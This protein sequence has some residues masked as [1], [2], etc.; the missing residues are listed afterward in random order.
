[1]KRYYHFSRKLACVGQPQSLPKAKYLP[2]SV[3]LLLLALCQFAAIGAFGQ[4]CPPAAGGPPY[5][6]GNVF[7]DYGQDGVKD[8]NV[9]I[10]QPIQGVLVRAFNDAGAMVASGSSQADG[11]YLLVNAGLV[12]G[13]TYRLEFSNFPAQ[14]FG[15]A[16]G[17]GNGTSVQFAAAN[18]CNNNFALSQPDIYCQSNPSFALNCYIEGPNTG[19]GDVLISIPYNA[20]PQSNEAND[21]NQ[22]KHEAIASAIGTTYGLAYQRH[23]KTLFA[24]AFMKRFAGF[25]PGGP[26]AIYKVPNPDD[27]VNSGSLFLNLSTVLGVANVAGADPHNFTTKTSGGDV[28]DANSYNAVTRV[29][30]GDMDISDDELS[31]WTINLA[32]R[33][34]YKIPLGTD[35]KNPVAPTSASQITVIPLASAASP[36][37]GLPTGLNNA[38]IRPF[39]L[40]FYKGKVYVSLVTNGQ[41]GGALR[42]YVYSYDPGPGTFTKELDF[43]LDYN[44][45]CGFGLNNSCY[46]PAKWQP[47]VN[48]NARPTPTVVGPSQYREDGYP[49]P[50]LT[51]IEFDI[52][53]NMILGMRDRFGDQE[54]RQAPRPDGNNALVTGDAFGDL[55]KATK[56]TTGWTINMA[57][58]TDPTTA[59]ATSEPVFGTDNYEDGGFYHEETAMGSLGVLLRANSLVTPVMD[60]RAAAFSNGVDW[61]NLTPANAPRFKSLTVLTG[62]AQNPFGKAYGLGDIEFVCALAPIEIGNRVW[63]D[64]NKNGIQDPNEPPLVGVTVALC[65]SAGAAIPNATAVTDAKGQYIFSSGEGTNNA[66]SKF[67]LAIKPLTTYQV[68]ITALG[69]NASVTGIALTDVTP[70]TPGEPGAVNSGATINNND[71]KLVAGKPTI[72]FITGAEGENNHTYDFALFCEKPVITAT[73]YTEAT[74]PTNGNTTPNNNASLKVTTDGTKA[75]ISVTG[76]PTTTFA[77]ATAVP[78]SGANA[79]MVTFGSLNGTGRLALRAGVQKPGLLHRHDCCGDARRVLPHGDGFD[80]RQLRLLLRGGQHPHFDGHHQREIAGQHPVCVF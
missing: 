1:M 75:A 10:D 63:N 66:N 38:E 18:T 64:L 16:E 37:P 45:G 8:A 34:L 30:L 26:A 19:A 27:D 14:H 13:T 28:I 73:V 80:A 56:T 59:L 5:I 17:T 4:A 33:E 25:G 31:L 79:G 60:P 3:L 20:T 44:R 57:D 69:S 46:G 6:G 41:A 42:G 78:T 53:G 74:C 2:Y 68:K 35:R 48:S 9:A 43:T 12:A 51:D 62:A 70:L 77:T 58:F 76:T 32:T 11:T 36:L 39:G 67:N 23:S 71:A 61:Y 7:L 15:S 47:W 21:D 54:G 72:V 65:D 24:A 49:Q 29:G 55:L 50:I 22:I 40:K 52:S